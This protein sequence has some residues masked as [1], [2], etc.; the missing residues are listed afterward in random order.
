M[1]VYLNVILLFIVQ[2]WIFDIFFGFRFIFEDFES[3]FEFYKIKTF[4][5][6][7]AKGPDWLLYF[8]GSST[9]IQIDDLKGYLIDRFLNKLN[10]AGRLQDRDIR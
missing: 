6:L 10:E 7:T 5:V 9:V 3:F 4:D 1:R 8:F 2:Y